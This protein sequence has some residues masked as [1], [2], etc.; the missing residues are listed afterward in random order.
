MK[1]GQYIL[2]EHYKVTK[3]QI[4]LTSD[5]HQDVFVKGPQQRSQFIDLI[6]VLKVF[7][8]TSEHEP[9]S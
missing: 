5:L 2:L 7:M 3:Q 1:A 8:Q 9:L 4:I 6:M